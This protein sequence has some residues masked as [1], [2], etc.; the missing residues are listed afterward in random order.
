MVKLEISY[1][2]GDVTDTEIDNVTD[3]FNGALSIEALDPL[4]VAASEWVEDNDAYYAFGGYGVEVTSIGKKI[5]FTSS[6]AGQD[7][8]GSTSI[9]N[10]IGNLSGTV[11]TVQP[12]Q[13]AVA[14]VDEITLSGTNGELLITCDGISRLLFFNDSID[15]S[16]ADFVTANAAAYAAGGVTVTY[17]SVTNKLKFTSSVAGQD[18][19]GSTTA[20]TMEGDF[21][22]SVVYATS[23]RVA[24]ARIDEITLT[25]TY[26][27]AEIKCNGYI[28]YTDVRLWPII[29]PTT[30]WSTRDGSES[31]NLLE[32]LV[33]EIALMKSK[34]RHFI[35]LNMYEFDDDTFF[36]MVSNLQDPINKIGD[37]YR[38]FIPN[39]GSYNVRDREWTI[40]LIE[41]GDKAAPA[42]SMSDGEIAIRAGGTWA[43]YD[44]TDATTLTDDGGGLISKW[45]DKLGSGHD[46]IAA[47][48]ARPT[49]TANGILFNGSSNYM[50][51]ATANL[52]QPTII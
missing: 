2:L 38:V 51:T 52:D 28:N 29:S 14:R 20:V 15:Q 30:S 46:L 32:L 27:S 24:Q 5:R 42:G 13:T 10:F 34:G 7:F 36:N 37:N 40:D 21:A 4:A 47:G 44:F 16:G 3:Q 8:T 43:W 19:T 23:N 12:N 9:S 26:G 31:S 18:F 33:D 25:G 39:R 1:E 35:Q 22:G 17:N 41:I 11:A 49:L 48:A 50:K 45:E 6:V